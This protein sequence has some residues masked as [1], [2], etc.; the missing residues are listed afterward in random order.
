MEL[1]GRKIHHV[2]NYRPI[3]FEKIGSYFLCAKVDGL[4]QIYNDEYKSIPGIPP[5]KYKYFHSVQVL[6]E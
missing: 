5:A 2:K 6:N 1:D 4:F 3:D